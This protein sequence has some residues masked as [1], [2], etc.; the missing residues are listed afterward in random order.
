VEYADVKG[1]NRNAVLAAGGGD[2]D[3]LQTTVVRFKGPAAQKTFVLGHGVDGDDSGGGGAGEA[4]GK[5]DGGRKWSGYEVDRNI[6]MLTNQNTSPP[7]TTDSELIWSF[8][9]VEGE[10]GN[11]VRAKLRIASYLNSQ[12]D[13]LYFMAKNRA[14]SIADY[15]LT[16]QKLP[17][18]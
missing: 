14:V 8:E 15:D 11:I 13:Q 9:K 18:L 1:S 3:P 6:F 4:G 7:I 17:K 10:G 2:E 16:L 12:Q 5:D